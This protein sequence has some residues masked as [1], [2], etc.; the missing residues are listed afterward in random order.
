MT[1]APAKLLLDSNVWVDLFASDRPGRADATALV[2]HAMSRQIALLYAASSVKDVYYL[3]EEREKR[4]VRAS[5][6]EVTATIA[7]AV[8]EYAWGCVLSM[9]EMAT[10]VPVDQSDLWIATKFCTVHEDL[11]DDLVLAAMERSQ[12]DFLVTSDETLLRKSPVAAL[13]PHDLLALMTA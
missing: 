11:E 7:A 1:T 13:S 5:G 2:T 8:N 12:A 9:G 3:L 4:R 6:A 10:V